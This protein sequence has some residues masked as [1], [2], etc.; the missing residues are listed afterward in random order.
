MVKSN[1]QLNFHSYSEKI[2]EHVW[3]ALVALDSQAQDRLCCSKYARMQIL[4]KN[5]FNVIFMTVNHGL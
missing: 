4:L 3:N 2:L 1:L 5:Y